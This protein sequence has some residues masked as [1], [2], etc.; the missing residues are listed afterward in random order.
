MQKMELVMHRPRN[1]I[2]F[3][4]LAVLLVGCGQKQLTPE[5]KALVTQ[6]RAEVAKID[7]DVKAAEALEGKGLIGA[8]AQMRVQT[9]KNTQAMLEQRAVAI[10][11]GAPIKVSDPVPATKPDPARVAALEKDIADQE[12]KIEAAAAR[13]AGGGGL[14]GALSQ[15]TVETERSTLAA[16]RMQ[17]YAAKYGLPALTAVNPGGAGAVGTTAAA[18]ASGDSGPGQSFDAPADTVLTV[19]LGGKRLEKSGYQDFLTL[20]LEIAATGLDKPARAIKGSMIFTDL[21]NE[22]KMSI[23]WTINQRLQP[24]QVIHTKDEGIEYNEF[25]DNHQWLAST[26]TEDMRVHFR[27]ESILYED[28]TRREFE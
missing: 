19:A 13:S 16:L 4:V 3:A 15:M 18:P 7:A 6:L 17:Y 5:E 27:V 10:E 24:G 21:F 26:K 1:W 28:G 12:K 2:G 25:L 22:P 14:L 8:I 11:T 20:N 9:L 23:G